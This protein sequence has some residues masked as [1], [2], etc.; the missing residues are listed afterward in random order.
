MPQE[1]AEFFEDI[2][3]N[4]LQLNSDR[5]AA[6]QQL[7]KVKSDNAKLLM[8]VTEMDRAR[9]EMDMMVKEL[10]GRL[11]QVEE[12]KAAGADASKRS[13]GGGFDVEEEAA[14]SASLSLALDRMSYARQLSDDE[15]RR[16][17]GR[18]LARNHQ[19]LA[20]YRD[21]VANKPDAP[22]D[23]LAGVLRKYLTRQRSDL[24]VVHITP[25]LGEVAELGALAGTVAGICQAIQKK[26]VY[27][28]VILPKYDTIN[29]NAVSELRRVD[30]MKFSFPFG[31]KT[32]ENH[33]WTGVV[34]G[35][36]VYFIEPVTLDFF[37]RG[38][39]Y[40]CDDDF[41]RFSYF[42]RAS[43]ELLLALGKMPN[44]IHLH[45]W[46]TALVAPLYWELFYHKGLNK[47]RIVFTCH[48]FKYQLQE[49]PRKLELVGLSPDFLNQP[50]RMQDNFFTDK[51]NILKGGIVF[52]NKVT[53]ISAQY[54]K[55]VMTAEGGSGMHSTL[56]AHQ[57]KFMGVLGGLD[58]KKWNPAIDKA[59]PARY[60]MGESSREGKR[61]CKKALLKR[62][63][64]SMTSEALN[65]PLVACFCRQLNNPEILALVEQA[66]NS[67]LRAG[68]RFIF[69]GSSR[70]PRMQIALEGLSRDFQRGTDDG[71]MLVKYDE[72]LARLM[73]AG[74]DIT[75][76]LP[77]TEPGSQNELIALRYGSVPVARQLPGWSDCVFDVGD[78]NINK[79][80]ANGFVY[81][82]TDFASVD[83]T[84]K[85]ALAYY[86]NPDKWQVL[87]DQ[88]MSMDFSWDANASDD[89]LAMYESVK[90]V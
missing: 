89:Y 53:T 8:R 56:K 62:L 74:S 1:M 26:S 67:T 47:S 20:L 64:M 34:G 7:Q 46:Q 23:Q 73:Y 33:V 44:V 19:L 24:T 76:S 66:I 50:D 80:D 28:E 37:R 2:Q 69:M 65:K 60:S 52:S 45:N 41:E 84:L 49:E 35:I 82:G 21:T 27:V 88:G 32:F 16:L 68:G 29:K 10:R 81:G 86:A 87:V 15:A 11:Q 17:R 71:R 78:P 90:A 55:E 70:Q 58:E 12:A 4:I 31:G 39:V 13:S 42:C 40:G 43:L 51:V 54:A 18:L 59:L 38:Q 25:E 3:Q 75:L 5:M 14:L 85:R 77:I 48:N 30:S 57:G 79:R 72:D 22:D 6:L 83:G 63:D 9:I 61:T 36:P